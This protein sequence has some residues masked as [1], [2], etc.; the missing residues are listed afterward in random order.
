MVY[1]NNKVIIILTW[2][3]RSVLD[4]L[5]VGFRM[6]LKQG[7]LHLTCGGLNSYIFHYFC[8]FILY[9]FIFI[10]F[11]IYFFIFFFLIFQLYYGL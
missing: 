11:F 2:A 1:N 4:G 10:F 9:F 5:K 3:N 6:E 7:T 8:F